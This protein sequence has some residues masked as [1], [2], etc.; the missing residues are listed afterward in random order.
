MRGM[1]LLPFADYLIQHIFLSASAERVI[2]I[3]IGSFDFSFLRAN[4]Y[5]CL[6]FHLLNFGQ[7]LHL[8]K[9]LLN[10]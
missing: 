9:I 5:T 8:I 2:L 4:L 10:S 7:Y 3:L 6:K 1:R